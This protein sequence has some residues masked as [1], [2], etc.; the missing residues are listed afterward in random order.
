[1]SS[2][3]RNGHPAATPVARLCLSLDSL[4]LTLQHKGRADDSCANHIH[5]VTCND[6]PCFCTTRSRLYFPL[7]LSSTFRLT[8]TARQ[9]LSEPF[10]HRTALSLLQD[11]SSI[12][13]ALAT[14]C[15]RVQLGVLA[16][17][18]ELTSAVSFLRNS[19]LHT[20]NLGALG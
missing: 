14:P 7:R 1:M 20:P 12:S 19:G 4:E 17:T 5:K 2:S 15:G 13:A 6:A 18:S 10:F 3:R 9:Y 8:M 11:N 16:V